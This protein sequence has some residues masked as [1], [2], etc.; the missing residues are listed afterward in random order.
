[1]EQQNHSQDSSLREQVLEHLFVGEVLKHLWRKGRNDMEVLRASVDNAGYDLVIDCN[2]VM[3]HVQ[4]KSSF[5]GAKT[6]RQKIHTNLV[7]KPSGCV[8]WIYFDP[9]TID[10][11]P[12]LWLGGVPNQPLPDLGDRI[13]K[14]TKGDRTGLKAERP[15]HR[16]VNKGE[17]T[18]LQSMDD[19]IGVLFGAT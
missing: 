19:L 2:G 17:F 16:V 1:M 9:E 11:G 15:M 8:V 6:A 4:L 7:S 12:F 3:R 13:A 10:L 18:R 14:H 5:I